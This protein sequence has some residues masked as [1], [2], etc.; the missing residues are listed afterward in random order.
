MSMLS[1]CLPLYSYLIVP[2]IFYFLKSL[3]GM[4]QEYSIIC[5]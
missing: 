5:L 3:S 2:L 1:F 4:I